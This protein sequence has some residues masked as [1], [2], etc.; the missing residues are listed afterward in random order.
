MLDLSALTDLILNQPLLGSTVKVDGKETDAYAFL[1]VVNL[2]EHRDK[3]YMQTLVQYL[4]SKAN[5]N[6]SLAPLSQL[7]SQTSAPAIG[8][9]LTERLINVPTEVV[10]P[11]YTMLV[12]EIQWALE[13]NEPYKFSHY[14]IISKTYTEIAS[15]L[16]E[17]DERP[18]KKKKASSGA[19]EIMYFHPEDEVLQRYALCHGSYNYTTPQDDGHSDSKRAFQ[20]LGIRPQS[21]AILIEAAKFQDAVKAIAEYLKPPT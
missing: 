7:L 19:A 1:S 8:L 21:Y 15:T 20:E 2:Q 12:E 9:V 5:S 4:L 3:P 6:T 10:P 14:L 18:K 13:E 16:D 11:M 17:E